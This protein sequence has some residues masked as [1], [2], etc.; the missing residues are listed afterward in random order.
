MILR[1]AR[2]ADVEFVV[3]LVPRFVENGVAP[4]ETRSAAGLVEQ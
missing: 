4:L 1:D 3:G 2:A